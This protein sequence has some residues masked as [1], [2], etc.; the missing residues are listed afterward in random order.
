MDKDL[1]CPF[2]AH[3]ISIKT[4][5]MITTCCNGDP[6]VDSK[7]GKVFMAQTHTLEE[8]F[9][10][11][12]FQQIRDNLDNGIRDKNCNKCWEV[13]DI[14][15]ESP[16]LSELR[17]FGKTYEKNNKL[18]LIDLALGNQCNLKCRTCNPTDSSYWIKEFYDLD[19]TIRDTDYQ[20]FQKQNIFR[21]EPDSG[22][23]QS[24]KSQSLADIEELH[25]FGGEPFMIKTTWDILEHAV[26]K[27]YAKNIELSFN[28]N[29]TFWDESRIDIFKHFRLVGIGLSLDGIGQRFEYMRHPAKWDQVFSNIEKM[30]AWRE[31][32]RQRRTLLT[33]YTASSY[34]VY[35]VNEVIDF[36][37]KY[38]LPFFI[39]PVYHPNNFA[40]QHIPRKIKDQLY[41]HFKGTIEQDTEYWDEIDK[42]WNYMDGS[43]D[44]PEQWAR[45]LKDIE[46]RDPYRGESF[47][48]IFSEYYDLI[49]K[50]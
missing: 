46:F 30:L 31:Q 50:L 10:S 17:W 39:N 14:G 1:W 43:V 22:F 27:G 4:S 24:L 15:G 12:E 8:A 21:I 23:Y 9:N 5:G 47:P 2:A 41:Q 20:K 16:R 35:Y 29:C 48:R 19:L 18:T 28:T 34:N 44:D 7:T 6:V 26:E 45:F 36:S 13:E 32:D 11:P 3:N 40:M 25:F 49:L 42:I 33:H 38:D 37:K